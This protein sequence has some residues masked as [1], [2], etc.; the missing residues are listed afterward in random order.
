MEWVE[1]FYGKQYEWGGLFEGGVLEHNHAQAALIEQ[2][3]GSGIKRVLELG[4]GGGQTAA[5]V[6]AMGHSVVAV[7]LIESAVQNAQALA[8]NVQ[9]GDMTVIQGDFYEIDLPNQF[10]V[11]CYWDGFGIGTDLDQQRLLARIAGWLKPD[12]CALID[13]STPWYAASVVGRQ[14]A[15]GD[16]IRRYD[17]D[18]DQCRWLDKW[19]LAEDEN[20]AVMQSLRCYSPADLR[21]LLKGTGLSLELVEAGGTMDW[22]KGEYL[23]K[24]P[25]EKAMVYTAKLVLDR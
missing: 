18:A 3:A 7:D 11:V 1:A 17:F 19:W 20:Q 14:W 13:C 15:V 8:E 24:A 12:G 21:L 6:A 23:K 2:L 9:S 4:A 25:L 5:A 22:E 16:A 10:D